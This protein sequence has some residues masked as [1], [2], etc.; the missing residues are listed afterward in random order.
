MV[1]TQRDDIAE[2][3]RVM[4]SHGMTTL[5]WDR[6]RGHAFTYDVV[7]LGNNYRIDEI[8]SALGLVQLKKLPA[9]NARRKAITERYRQALL[10]GAFPGVQVPFVDTPGQPSYHIFPMLL[11]E[12][13]DRRAFMETMRNSGVQTSIHYPPI[14]LF[15]YYRQRYPGISLPITEAMAAREVTLPL[16]PGMRDEDVDY[17]LATASEALS[18]ARILTSAPA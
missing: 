12:D 9:N 4:R 7:D 14:H 2:K 13:V 17:V 5:T 15:S 10:G 1:I 11:P 18:A 8:R 3:V 6:H 16:Y